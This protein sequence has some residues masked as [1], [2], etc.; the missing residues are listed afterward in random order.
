MKSYKTGVLYIYIEIFPRA[1]LNTVHQQG[2]THGVIS[3]FRKLKPSYQSATSDPGQ[4]P[5]SSFLPIPASPH[6]NALLPRIHTATCK[7]T[8]YNCQSPQET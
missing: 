8:E 5:Q 7:D 1:A 3:V 2:K 4:E 6:H